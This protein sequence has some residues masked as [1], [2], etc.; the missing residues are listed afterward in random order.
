MAN[1]DN[2]IDE[3][4]DKLEVFLQ[5][6]RNLSD[7]IF[8]L[9]AEIKQL[10]E[11]VNTQVEEFVEKV[12]EENIPKVV[13]KEPVYEPEPQ[14]KQE[15]IEEYA[16]PTFSVASNLP[17]TKSNLEKF[18]GENLISKIGIVILVIGVAIGAKYAIENKW[19]S[20]LM[21]IILGYVLGGGLLGLALKL[22]KQY[23]NF[24]AVLLS[25]A[26]AIMYFITYFAYDF[27][28]LIPQIPAFGLMVVFTVFTV[29]AAIH[30]NRQIIAHIG[31]VGAYAVPFL[32]SDG[33]GKIAVLLSYMAI[34]NIGILVISIKKYWKPLCYVSFG[35][36]WLIYF[37]CNASQHLLDSHF[38]LALTFL[39]FFF[40]LFYAAILGYKFIKNEK[41]SVDDIVLLLANSFIFYGL[42]YSILE[43]HSSQTNFLGLFTFCNA[44]LHC[45]VSVLI[46][47]RKLVDKSLFYLTF[48][49][50]LIFATITIPVQFSGNWITLLWTGEAVL[51]FWI[52]RKK[53]VSF[54]EYLSYPL[55]LLSSISLLHDWYNGYS[56]LVKF[57]PILN[58]HCA[59]SVLF[60]AAFGWITWLNSKI[61]TFVSEFQKDFY[62]ITEYVFPAVLII[63]MYVAFYLEIVHF[64]DTTIIYPSYA[65]KNIWLL[66]YSLFFVS[67]FSFV[68]LKKIKNQALGYFSII[69]NVLTIFAFL[70]V[71]FIAF[72]ILREC[73]LSK[74]LCSTALN[75]GIRY[76]SLIF[77]ASTVYATYLYT[78]ASFIS[79]TFKTVFDIL[80]HFSILW[81]VSSEFLHWTDMFRFTE[82]YKI[83]SILWGIYALLLIVLGIWKKKKHLRIGAMVLFGVTLVKLFTYDINH[84][85]TIAKTIVFVSLGVLLLVISFLYNKYKRLISDGDEE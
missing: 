35:L 13:E 15:I 18:I 85:G 44:A 33:S 83:L 67:A 20:P 81:I 9:R 3:L 66:N 32:L 48:G 62:K 60:I 25:G 55:M 82:G 7:A 16:V 61:T 41:F 12:I 30:Y 47:K 69:L 14:P 76:I 40:V 38:G 56:Y 4:S 5:R 27:Y 29:G 11:D 31:L 50:M 2:R 42:G 73:Y 21:R 49:L 46:Y 23:V 53:Q 17:R 10:K 45:L 28:D 80:L 58:I 6:Q 71:G 63:T 8:E 39:I 68:N 79:K 24:S 77:F 64:Y 1:I 19:I 74:T 70:I 36:T 72:G 22:K 34:I 57:T 54:Y 59:T 43:Q 51:L 52:G 75:I 78:K 65:F 37:V 84:L 26:S